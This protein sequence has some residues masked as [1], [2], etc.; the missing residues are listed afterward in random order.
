MISTRSGFQVEPGMTD[1]GL[2]TRSSFLHRVFFGIIEE[3]KC[4]RAEGDLLPPFNRKG[5]GHNTA[6][7][8]ISNCAVGKQP[9]KIS[10][11]MVMPHQKK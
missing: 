10:N 7:G 4:S 5:D 11:G 6:S 9:G 3:F 1:W 2:F 8:D